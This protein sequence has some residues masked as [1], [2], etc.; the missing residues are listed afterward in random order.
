MYKGSYLLIFITVSF[1][2]CLA[3]SNEKVLEGIW[4]NEE[5]SVFIDFYKNEDA[6]NARIVAIKDSL[7]SYGEAVRDI[8]NSDP[9]LRARKVVGIDYLKGLKAKDDFQKWTG[10]EIYNFRNGNTYNAIM[11]LGDSTTLYIKGYWSYF[12]FL[13]SNTRWT[14]IE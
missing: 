5:R 3:Q 12:R 9:S 2:N 4:S 10:G 1:F 13:G 11:T 6:W 14:K 7:D 8:Y